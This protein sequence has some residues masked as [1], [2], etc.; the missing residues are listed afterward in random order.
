MERLAQ[1]RIHN[2]IGDE[3]THV[4]AQERRLF[5]QLPRK[6]ES[7]FGIS[8]LRILPTND[9]HEAR[10]MSRLRPMNSQNALRMERTLLQQA[11]GNGG[12]VGSNNRAGRHSLLDAPDHSLLDV[13]VFYD[14]FD[15]NLALPQS[16][17]VIGNRQPSQSCAWV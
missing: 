4:L 10:Y 14:T 15:D 8:E 6:C 16:R 3:S 5:A 13:E 12:G 17:I 7:L 11:R 9:L 2:S 1:H